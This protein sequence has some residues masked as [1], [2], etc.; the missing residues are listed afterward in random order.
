[1]NK[2]ILRNVRLLLHSASFK[3]TDTM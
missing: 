1:L 2:N 3:K